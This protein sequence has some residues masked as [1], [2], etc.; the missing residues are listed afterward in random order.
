MILEVFPLGAFQSNCYIVADEDLKEGILID[1]GGDPDTILKRCE[2]LGIK[3]KYILLTH[4]HGDHI[5]GVKEVKDKTGVKVLLHRNDEYLVKG[6][7]AELSRLFTSIH[8]FD[9]DIYV[10]EGD[11]F[12]IGEM[13]IEVIET[14]GHTPGGV[15][16]KIGDIIFTGDT[17]FNGS[18]GRTDFPFA[19]H[20][21]LVLSIKNKIMKFSDETKL[22]PGHGPYTTVG[23]ERKY[24]PFL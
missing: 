13:D 22:Y 16:Y 3:L 2:K 9:I 20:E 1:I 19:S 8:P 12:K 15:C 5:A 24:N 11:K 18:I 21:E 14:P 17:I 4:G 23:Y 7:N 6:A 10:C